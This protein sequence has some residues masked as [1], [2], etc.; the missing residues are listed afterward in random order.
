MMVRKI[1]SVSG[2]TGYRHQLDRA[3]RF[4]DRVERPAGED[5]LDLANMDDVAFQDMMWAFFQNCW[6]VKDWIF[7]DPLVPK[8]I[9]D[10]VIDL[11]HHHSPDLK[12][13]QQLCNGTK[14]LGPRP[15]AS[16]HH[17]DMTIVPEQ[18]RFEMDCMIDDGRGNLVSGKE[19]ARRCISEWE[20]ILKSQ[21][22]ATGR[23][24]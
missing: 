19:L 23:L 6:H 12:M 15:G 14:H 10:A 7:H 9:K 11:A 4:L 22:L 5:E 20:R 21:G 18:G 17:T 3:R 1:Q 24:S 16:H 13:C 2:V 8:A